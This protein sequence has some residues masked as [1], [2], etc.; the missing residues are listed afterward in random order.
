MSYN[1]IK[2]SSKDADSNGNVSLNTTDVTN[3]SNT[4]DN[5]TL[6]YS[7]TNWVNKNPDWVNE[8]KR[9]TNSVSYSAGFDGNYN[10][11][12]SYTNVPNNF[13]RAHYWHKNI[14]TSVYNNHQ[15]S[16]DNDAELEWYQDTSTTRLYYAVK[17]NNPGVYRLFAKVP[18][19]KV[20]GTDNSSIEVQWSNADNSIAYSPRFRIHRVNI[21]SS[22]CIGYINAAGGERVCLYKH[23]LNNTPKAPLG[24]SFLDFLMLVEK[25]R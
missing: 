2:V 15:T 17:I 5:Q 9:S 21:K 7:G 20:Y 12:L 1:V 8:N 4:T 24:S 3:I 19:S 25:L 16:S 14:N 6:A 11:I 22:P 13:D 18:L 10:L 23:T